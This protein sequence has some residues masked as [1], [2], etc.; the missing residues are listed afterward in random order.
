[1]SGDLEISG[2]RVLEGISRNWGAVSADLYKSRRRQG[3]CFPI[4]NDSPPECIYTAFGES[5]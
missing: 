3:L 5:L 1:M 2:T 4:F